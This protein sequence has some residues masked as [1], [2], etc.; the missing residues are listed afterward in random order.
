MFQYALSNKYSRYYNNNY[1]EK[2]KKGK[3]YCFYEVT[4][5]VSKA[6]FF[7]FL[8]TFLFETKNKVNNL[9]HWNDLKVCGAYCCCREE[10]KFEGV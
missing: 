4:R 7:T 10:K 2:G 9:V 3:S 6:C 1:K 5:S 8:F